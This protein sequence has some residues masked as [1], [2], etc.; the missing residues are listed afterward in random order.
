VTLLNYQIR[1]ELRRAGALGD[2]KDFITDVGVKEFCAG[3]RILFTQN[4][5]KNM[6]V[7][8]GSLGNVQRI[9]G[10]SLHVKLDDGREI[11]VN[12]SEYKAVSHG[13]AT[14]IHKS[15]GATVDKTLFLASKSLSQELSYVAMTRHRS[16][17]TIYADETSL[18]W[19]HFSGHIF[20]SFSALPQTRLGSHNYS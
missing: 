15:Q 9:W 16:E 7:R 20:N 1:E 10:N 6:D 3:D 2:G 13:Y 12:V 5:Y 14:T 4:E 8:N 18:M 17:V 11:A 19:Q